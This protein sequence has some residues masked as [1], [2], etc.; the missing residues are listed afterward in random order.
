MDLRQSADLDDMI[1]FAA[2]FPLAG[3]SFMVLRDLS[4]LL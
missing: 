3:Q 1:A 4:K 2:Q